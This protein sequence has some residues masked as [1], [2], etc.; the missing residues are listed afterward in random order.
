MLPMFSFCEPGW[1]RGRG[2]QIT[3]SRRVRWSGGGGGS[4]GI[5]QNWNL[6]GYFRFDI[7]RGWD[8][9]QR[10]GDI[11][12]RVE[13]RVVPT[14]MWFLVEVSAKQN[15]TPPDTLKWTGFV[16]PRTGVKRTEKA[17]RAPGVGFGY[18][19]SQGVELEG[20]ITQ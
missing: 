18:T 12:F 17:G 4:S 9:H 3:G 15:D 5:R 2:E 8:S 7:R 1:I 6:P 16:K 20:P 19:P 11:R 13:K 14:K 10:D